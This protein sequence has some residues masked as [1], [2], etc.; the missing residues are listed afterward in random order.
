[1]GGCNL[2]EHKDH[3]VA[4]VTALLDRFKANGRCTYHEDL[5]GDVSTLSGKMNIVL[6]IQG[7]ILV[8]MFAILGLG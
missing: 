7:V 5:R 4:T 8:I 1:M 2:C 6:G 3:E